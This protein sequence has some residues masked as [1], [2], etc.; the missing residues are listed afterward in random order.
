[1][2]NLPI[3]VFKT[4]AGGFIALDKVTTVSSEGKVYT[5]E[6]TYLRVADE[7]IE[8]FNTAFLRFKSTQDSNLADRLDNLS[9]QFSEY[10]RGEQRRQ[11][12]ERDYK[13]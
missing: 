3:N 5:G 7:D 13:E 6:E 10:V 9:R 2:S 4:R 11:S 12:E 1:M 8:R